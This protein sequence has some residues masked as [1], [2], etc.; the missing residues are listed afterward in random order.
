[1]QRSPVRQQDRFPS[2]SLI[3]L[4]VNRRTIRSSRCARLPRP[5][6]TLEA[7]QERWE[8]ERHEIERVL[9][10]TNVQVG[11]V[12]GPAARYADRDSRLVGSWTLYCCCLRLRADDGQTGSYASGLANCSR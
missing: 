2:A 10:E 7:K 4:N 12:D 8:R 3:R 5:L 1:M 6:V 9:L 11:G